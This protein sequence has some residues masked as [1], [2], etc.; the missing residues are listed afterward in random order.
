MGLQRDLRLVGNQANVA[1]TMFFIP[2]VLFEIPSNILLK[3]FKPHKWRESCQEGFVERPD[4]IAL[5][6]SIY[7]HFGIWRGHADPR[8]WYETPRLLCTRPRLKI[9]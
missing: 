8:I 7:L 6:I 2:Y 1:L 9:S 3:R 4:L 5:A